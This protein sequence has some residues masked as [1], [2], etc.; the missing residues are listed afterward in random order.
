MSLSAGTQLGSFRITGQ[1]GAGGMGEVYRA[2]DTKLGRDV[3]IKTLPA[4]LASDKDRLARFEREAKLL[5]SLN[6]A[7]IA[8]V[9]SLD[10]HDNT[11]Y[12]A[13]ELIEGETLEEKLKSGALP[14]EEALRIAL[15]IAEA[16]EAAHEKGVVH[17]D[18]KPANI[19]LTS[20]GEVKVL[21][22][23]LAKAFSGDPNQATLAHSPALSNAMT[24]QG[25]ILGTAGYMS[26]EQ[27]SGQATD[28]RAD[29]WAFG[30]VLY[31][32]LT[33]LPLF[34]GESVPHVLAAVLQTEPNWSRLPRKLHPRLKSLLERCLRKKVRDRY[35][36]IGDVRVDI[37]EVLQ[38]PE[39]A[40][41]APAATRS[42]LP[43]AAAIAGVALALGVVLASVYFLGSRQPAVPVQASA[44][45]PI[46]RYMITPP[47][48]APLAS[49]NPTDVAISADGKRIAYLGQNVENDSVEIY[50]R[51]LD[52]LESRLLPGTETDS[53]GVMPFFSPDGQSIGFS[54]GQRGVYS[55]ATDGRPSVKL[56][57]APEQAFLGASW[58]SDD[59]LIYSS[60]N[61]LQKNAPGSAG[62][63]VPL[64]RE[65][66]GSN[67]V[68]RPVALPGGRAV[69]FSDIVNGVEMVSVVDLET[70]EEKELFEGGTALYAETGHIVFGRDTTLMAV[71][72]DVDELSVTGDPVAVLQGVRHPGPGTATDFDLSANGTLVYVPVPDEPGTAAVVWV[73]RTGEV[74][75]RA[76]SERVNAPRDPRLSP[77]GQHL[78]LVTG[79]VANGDLWS[80]DLSG[81]PPI[82]LAQLDDVRFPV[83]SPDGREV[84]FGWRQGGARLAIYGLPADGSVLTPRR[85][86]TDDLD[87]AP[88]SWSAAGELIVL[89]NRV[90][91]I[92]IDA[93]DSAGTGESRRIVSTEFFEGDAALSPDGQWLAY[94][95][96]RTGRGEIWVQAYPDGVAMRVSTNGG[97]EPRWSTDGRELYYLQ[98]NAMLAVAVETEPEFSFAAPQELFTGPYLRDQSPL[99]ASYDVAPDGRFLMIQPGLGTDTAPTGI[100]VV[101]NWT[102]EL[103]QRVRPRGQ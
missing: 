81:R 25:L 78:L 24:Q 91:N 82:P 1:L 41:L 14:L 63:P 30:V 38:D 13:M 44:P 40:K 21:D 3:A 19:M 32:M 68:A 20:A 53:G 54:A 79:A 49:Q 97:Y 57:D 100:V 66:E 6:H 86:T 48:S 22:F 36:S 37:E 65:R 103:K 51:E 33:G 92:D 67:F 56:L 73:D 46:S 95:S 72:F 39:G 80:Y 70:G 35:H 83:W 93:V 102:E 64:I 52:A 23:G 11:L 9:H 50:L 94:V 43:R 42:F 15:Q 74:V 26:P 89:V 47:A 4:A 31:E 99:V 5:A 85:L 28:Q 45:L 90:T 2:T 7:H 58:A 77:D 75:E 29:I 55:V 17:R 62:T 69:L 60:R 61:L 12:I 87:R 76:V 16:L 71:P 98:G 96:N 101:E 88:K 18:L 59:S 8:S 34:S 10:E 27:A 84:A